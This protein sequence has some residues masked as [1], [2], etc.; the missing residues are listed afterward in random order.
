MAEVATSSKPMTEHCSGTR[1]PDRLRA[2]I[3]PNALISSKAS[4]AVK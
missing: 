2:R 4:M 1:I 3:A